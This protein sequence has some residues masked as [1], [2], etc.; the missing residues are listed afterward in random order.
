MALDVQFPDNPFED[1][2]TF[3]DWYRQTIERN[4]PVPMSEIDGSKNP[5]DYA[6]MLPSLS[7]EQE[8]FFY[9]E[10]RKIVNLP[11]DVFL[12]YDPSSETIFVYWD[13][14][15]NVFRIGVNTSFFLTLAFPQITKT[16]MSHELAHIFNGDCFNV[17]PCHQYCGNI[18]MDVR[19]NA[20]L[21]DEACDMLASVFN[22]RVSTL[23]F[24]P[25]R[26]YP[27]YNLPV[28]DAGWPFEIAHNAYH[29]VQ[30]CL[31]YTSDAADE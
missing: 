7:D 30:P 29:M 22:F 14:Q 19:I 28:N 3:F 21:G 31:L 2:D 9:K 4:M 10:I 17:D 13:T 6:R 25:S 12:M 26:W 8:K 24:V 23:P 20:T 1:F 16:G 5:S 11:D 18:C 27:R 15:K